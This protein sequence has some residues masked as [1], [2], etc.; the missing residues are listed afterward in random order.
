MFPILRRYGVLASIPLLLLVLGVTGCGTP[1]P[2]EGP[3]AAPSAAP[4]TTAGGR[5]SPSPESGPAKPGSRVDSGV[6]AELAKLS[7]EDRA[8]AEKQKTCP[9]SGA[10]L[11]SM[12]VPYKVTLKGQTVFLCCDG[13][14]EELR[15]D[16]DKYLAKLK[17]TGPK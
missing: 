6:S 15:K 10:L 14:E 2:K 1:A 12:G 8:L 7:P 11:G 3:K 9:V 4:S 5:A 17:G 13:C 16:A